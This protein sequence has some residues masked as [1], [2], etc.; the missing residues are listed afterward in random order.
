M[1]II[2]SLPVKAGE[3]F[4]NKFNYQAYRYLKLTNLSEAPAQPI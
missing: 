4:V 2:I 3:S 1:K